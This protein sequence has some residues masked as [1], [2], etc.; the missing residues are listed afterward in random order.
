MTRLRVLT[1]LLVLAAGCLPVATGHVQVA[2]SE[3]EHMA[4]EDGADYRTDALGRV[5]VVHVR[6][7]SR[8]FAKGG[9]WGAWIGAAAGAVASYLIVRDIP[10]NMS[11]DCPDDRDCDFGKVVIPVI[12]TGI[13]GP[14]AGG[15]I[16]GGI[17]AWVGSDVEYTAR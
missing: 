12:M 15:L 10:G 13:L 16:G 17:G 5:A 1:A 8:G 2:R 4:T 7:R 9:N 14:S 3:L 6:S 11:G